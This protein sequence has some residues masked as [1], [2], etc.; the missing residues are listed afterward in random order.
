MRAAAVVIIATGLSEILAGSVP[1]FEPLYVYLVAIALVVWLDG[2]IVGALAAAAA[3]A[4][5]A[6]LFME[7][8]D[9]LWNAIAIP[10]GSAL[11]VIA[12]VGVVR[13][14]VRGRR[15]AEV[16]PEYVAPPPPL[17]PPPQP[18][19]TTD[20]AEVLSAI[21]ELR[22]DLRERE[23]TLER[24]YTQAR[25]ALT[26]RVQVAEEESAQLM[27][28]LAAA[29]EE[30]A[31]LAGRTAELELALSTSRAE[32]DGF[33]RAI[34]TEKQHAIR[35]SG[36]V[37]RAR[38]TAE[39]ERAEMAR[40]RLRIAELEQG[41]AEGAAAQTEIDELRRAIEVRD[42]EAASLRA[43]LT[44]LEQ[45]RKT[46]AVE[47]RRIIE[48]EKQR[49]VALSADVESARSQREQGT[50][51]HEAEAAALHARIAELEQSRKTEVA[52]LRRLIETEKQRAVA[53]SADVES[54]RSQREQGTKAHEAEAATLRARIAELEQGLAEG[55]AV[56]RGE[57]DELRRA[58]EV[59]RSRAED[60]IAERDQ[61]SA[62]FDQKLQ[63]I[64][65]HLAA[66][67]ETDLGKAVEEREEARAEARSLS[68]R[69][70]ALQRRADEE[71]QDSTRLL[72]ETR[73]AAQKEIDSLHARIA[74]LEAVPPAPPPPVRPRVL[75]AHPDA[76]LRT[77]AR[78]SLERAGYEIVSAAD[79]LEALRTAIAQR[80]DVVIADAV[81]PKMDGRELCQL[82]KSQEKT[83]HIRVILLTRANDDPPKG[84]LPPDEILRKPVPLETLKATLAT[85][86][87]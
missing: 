23:A 67:H 65:S 4:F 5:H 44:E 68:M 58:I 54:A 71:R 38:A 64:V 84:D 66:D 46:E 11:A 43:R 45:S 31:S 21:D 83:S 36:E 16:I 30:A 19:V 80:P 24:T 22:S 10:A 40:L 70:T 14:L 9:A 6:L 41:L 1:R 86:I 15:R 50:K 42:S 87:G 76:E 32:Q 12:V 69:L 74:K 18:I 61:I 17:L 27:R 56:A 47:L 29:R 13:G 52:E 73:T 55:A 72:A 81:M 37:E 51:E 57:V 59:E 53:L 33:R 48:T 77:N 85:L 60:A 28:A 7:R 25:E 35:L 78:A 2:V 79:G 75:I 3:I 62:E 26:S 39:S 34:E 82:L 49:A 8:G 20:N 63:T